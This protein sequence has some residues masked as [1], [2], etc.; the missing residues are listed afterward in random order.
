MP[1]MGNVFIAVPLVSMLNAVR[2]YK[3]YILTKLPH[4]LMN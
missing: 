1:M 4:E 2:S 3:V